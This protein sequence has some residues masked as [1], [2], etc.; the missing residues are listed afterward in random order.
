MN[1]R[2]TRRLR[3]D[4]LAWITALWILLQSEFSVANVIGGLAVALAVTLALPLPAMPL[5]PL[6]IHW[7]RLLPF[8][9]H[10]SWYF[11]VASAKVAWLAV[12]PASPPPTAL[13][14]IPLDVGGELPLALGV[15]LYNLQP[16]GTV[17][18]LGE[19]QGGIG[20]RMLTV[21]ILD[22]SS[23]DAIAREVASMHRLE[24]ALNRIFERTD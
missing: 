5:G 21:H 1:N 20:K 11:V 10:Y 16:G 2:L 18:D 15:M 23:A 8:L 7:F 17:T 9:A 24:T 22:A 3:P 4:H 19:S 14:D 13:V 6:R 12:R